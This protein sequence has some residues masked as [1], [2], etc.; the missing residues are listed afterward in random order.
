M[1]G[2]SG[3]RPRQG[4]GE[5][6]HQAEHT[7]PHHSPS[8]LGYLLILFAVAFLLLLMAYFQQQRANAETSDALK[9]SVS[10]V[11]AIQNMMEDN[12]ALRQQVKSL[13]Q[14]INDL[15]DQADS[16]NSQRLVLSSQLESA[17]D[18]LAAMDYLWR[19]QRFYSRGAF[20]DARALTDEFRKT[21]LPAALP[22]TNPSG[23]DGVSPMEQ[24]N[25]LLDAMDYREEP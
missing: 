2:P 14:Q 8:V 24:Y 17:Q 11:G 16:F 6:Q 15:G 10:A 12:D 7:R 18:Q 21:D 22:Q 25:A 19:I 5:L 13:E 23:V 3:K 9:E 4:A 1:S 20:D